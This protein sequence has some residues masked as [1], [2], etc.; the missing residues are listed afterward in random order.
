MR[1]SIGFHGQSFPSSGDL[2]DFAVPFPHRSSWV[3]LRVHA[4]DTP[5]TLAI[6]NVP[7]D[8]E[9]S[10]NFLG[11]KLDNRLNFSSHIESI[12]SKLSKTAGVFFRICHYVPECILINLYYSIVY[13]YLLYGV[14]IWG[15]ACESHLSPLIILQKKIVRTVTGSDFLATTKPLFHKTKILTV[16]DIYLFSLGIHMYKKQ[17]SN[18]I[19]LPTH[20]HFTRSRNNAVPTFQ[21]LTQCQR[22][23]KYKGPTTW[24]SIPLNIRQS[25]SLNSFKKM[26]K[27]YLINS[28]SL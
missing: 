5:L 10:I 3:L 9:S 1:T 16:K 25:N 26:Y 8:L 11:M 21:R 14:L 15:G 20:S 2:H 28:Y 22:S 6:D 4:I 23:I 12:C 13:P 18:S 24:N 19:I 7:V 27:K 17:S